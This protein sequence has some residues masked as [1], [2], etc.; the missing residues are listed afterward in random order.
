MERRQAARQACD[1][2]YSKKIK[3]DSKKPY[4]SHCVLYA[5]DCTYAAASRKVVSKKQGLRKNEEALQSRLDRLETHLKLVS[6][7]I[8]KLESL[9][10]QDQANHLS[11]VTLSQDIAF[12][13]PSQHHGS[14]SLPPLE[15]ILPVIEEYVA[16]FNSIF[17]LFD[18]RTLLRMVK[19]WYWHPHQR[20][21]TTWAAINVALALAH[22]LRDQSESVWSQS[23]AKYLE[24]AQSVL[25]Q[26]IMSDTNLVDVQILVGLVILFQ[27]TQ[28]LKPPTILIATALRLAHK[29][30]LHTRTSS[31]HLDRSTA[32]QRDRVFWIAY[33]LDKDISMRTRQPPIQLDADIDLDLPPEEA[34]DDD[35][36]FLVSTDGR[37]RMNF[38][39]ARVQL[40]HIQGSVY[41]YLYSSRSQN[42]SPEQRAQNASQIRDMLHHWD[43]QIPDEFSAT[44]VSAG[45]PGLM[46]FF[47]ILYSA[48]LSC[49]ALIS[50]ADSWN[51][52][53][54]QGLQ[55][56]GRK[57]AAGEIAPPVSLPQDWQILVDGSR[58]LMRLFMNVP[59]KDA[60]FVW[61]TTCTYISGLI[62]L[63]AN[64]LH[65]PH[66]ET[67]DVDKQLVD[68]A[69]Q[70]VDEMVLQTNHEQLRRLRDACKEL[71]RHVHVVTQKEGNSEVLSFGDF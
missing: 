10:S 63:T 49:L 29:L 55:D 58:D 47:C 66:G 20:E 53:W 62:C 38:F 56:Y 32:L 21:Q 5:T 33:T 12:H 22:R 14:M 70:F 36:G 9:A 57:A 41:D 65:N 69:L 45:L 28:N 68:T 6:E 17:P 39:R 64:N 19:E 18:P 1:L 15:E 61:M 46:R 67:V 2:C 16:T 54:V 31:L 50:K 30:G 44:A 52:Q 71:N 60:A 7:K 59:R 8:D 35:T 43:S 3:C 37:S 40:A 48:R 11:L 24:N 42:L 25:T 13:E 51:S 23:I 26:V 34:A 27:G 4:C